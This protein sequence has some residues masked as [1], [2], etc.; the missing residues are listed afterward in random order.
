MT[1]EIPHDKE[2]LIKT[3]KSL[4][5]QHNVD[6][7][8]VEELNPKIRFLLDNMKARKGSLLTIRNAVENM[9]NNL[10]CFEEILNLAKRTEVIN[11][12]QKSLLELFLY[13]QLAEG[14]FSETINVI[15]FML[16]ENG[17]DIYYDIPRPKFVKKFE[18]IRE[19]PIFM[20]LLFL[21][22]HGFKNFA[23]A[24]DR[25]LRNCIAHFE[26]EI[27]NDGTILNKKDQSIVTDIV[28]KIDYLGCYCTV[29]LNS[30]LMPFWENPELL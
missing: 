27:K 2:S 1:I 26:Y 25:Q 3:Q 12:K 29:V 24:V 14:F 11:P 15:A 6:F 16:I 21:A 4:C 19:I 18:E 13:L 30:I 20:R 9:L 7:R 8:G 10:S 23:H 22:E 5:S 28:S 17:H